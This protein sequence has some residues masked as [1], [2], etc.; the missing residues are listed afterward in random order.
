[1]VYETE[2]HKREIVRSLKDGRFALRTPRFSASQLEDKVNSFLQYDSVR[3]LDILGNDPILVS[4]Q[5][6]NDLFVYILRQVDARI[7]AKELGLGEK[8]AAQLVSQEKIMVAYLLNTAEFYLTREKFSIS[9]DEIYAPIFSIR[10]SGKITNMAPS[11]Y[12][13]NI[14]AWDGIAKDKKLY[15]SLKQALRQSIDASQIRLESEKGPIIIYKERHKISQS[16]Q[17]YLR[18]QQSPES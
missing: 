9:I 3:L 5:P 7:K 14:L 1:M 4:Q 15:A 12:G 8:G 11:I 6:E 13:N 2:V 10:E 16:V 17:H 18:G